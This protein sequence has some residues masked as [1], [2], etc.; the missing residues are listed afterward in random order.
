VT[1]YELSLA[2]NPE[3]SWDPN[4][5]EL[6]LSK[7]APLINSSIERQ[8]FVGVDNVPHFSL[9]SGGLSLNKHF[10]EKLDGQ[11]S[12]EG[13]LVRKWDGTISA[14]NTVSAGAQFL[15]NRTYK[16]LELD[17]GSDISKLEIGRS[18]IARG[19][20]SEKREA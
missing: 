16:G 15:N 18:G 7:L 8:S 4:F 20:I 19:H 2:L 11:V 12:A 5:Y 1:P 14:Y 17:L 3:F 13:T 10:V 9:I 6:D